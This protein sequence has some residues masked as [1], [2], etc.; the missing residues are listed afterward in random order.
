MEPLLWQILANIKDI[1]DETLAQLLISI[2]ADRTEL[3]CHSFMN[4][5]VADK[6]LKEMEG[7]I[8]TVNQ[9]LKSAGATQF[10]QIDKL[11]TQIHPGELFWEK[12]KFV[13]FFRYWRSFERPPTV[14]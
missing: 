8:S 13:I 9:T 2:W 11:I 5:F 1:N 10:I 4:G 14:S 3:T 7:E 12:K 6:Y